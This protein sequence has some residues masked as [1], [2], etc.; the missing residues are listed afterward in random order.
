MAIVTDPDLLTRF[1]VIFGTNQ[2]K[3]SIFPVGAD[4]S[5]AEQ[6][7]GAIAATGIKATTT[8]NFNINALDG[9]DITI[10][11]AAEGGRTYTF[12]DTITVAADEIHIGVALTNTIDNLVNAIN[13]DGV[14]GTAGTDWST[15]TL[16][17]E[18]FTATNNDPK[19]TFLAKRVGTTS[20]NKT[21]IAAGTSVNDMDTTDTVV[22]VLSVWADTTV[23]GGTGDSTAGV[24]INALTCAA[25]TGAAA[26]DILCVYDGINAGH[27]VLQT[28]TT[29]TS[30]VIDG[31]FQNT[32]AESSL[33]FAVK[34]DER[35]SGAVQETRDGATIQAIYS[36]AKDEYKTDSRTGVLADDLIRHEFP[37][38]PITSEQFEV[39]GGVAHAEWDWFEGDY[40]PHDPVDTPS[41]AAGDEYTVKKVRTGG[42]AQVSAGTARTE[43]QYA[44]IIT[45]GSLDSDAQVYY[46]Q[47]SVT[48]TPVDFSFLSVVNEPI[49]VNSTGFTDFRT[50]LKLFVRKKARTYAGSTIGD[51]GV[52]TLSTIVNRFPLT[53]TT[54]PAIVE[55]DAKLLGIAPWRAITQLLTRS[56]GVTA[57]VDGVT[58]TMTTAVGIHAAGAVDGD[59]VEIISG[60]V[61]GDLG[62]YTVISTSD[63]VLTL[64]TTENGAFTGDTVITFDVD[65]TIVPGDG[66]NSATGTQ[67]DWTDGVTTDA[68]GTATLTSAGAG[69]FA[70]GGITDS[71][72]V[73]ITDPGAGTADEGYYDITNV[74]TTTITISTADRD[75]TT[76]TAVDFRI[77][78]PGMYL[79]FRNETVTNA[80]PAS[81]AFATNTITRAD[82]T[83]D[84]TIAP[85]TIITVTGSENSGENDGTFTVL[86]RTSGTI[87]TLLD[88]GSLTAITTNGTDTTAVCAVSDGWTRTISGDVVAFNWKM[89]ANQATLAEAFQFVQHQLRQPSNINFGPDNGVTNI[90]RGDIN[91]LLMSFSTPTGTTLNLVIDNIFSDDINNMT[92]QDVTGRNRNQPFTSSG[93]LVFN[94]NF[95]NDAD[96]TYTL[97]FTN[98]D[99][100]GDNDNSNFGTAAAIIVQEPDATPI[101]GDVVG[102]GNHT[103]VTVNPDSAGNIN[104]PFTYNYSGNVQRGASTGATVA[105][106]TLVAIGLQTAQYAITQTNITQATGL[107]IPATASLERN[108]LV[109]TV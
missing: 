78:Q 26:F 63:T 69:D 8:F 70:A 39:G 97:F 43:R 75:L 104:I 88:P 94:A 50:F 48:T 101:T 76:D 109:G 80:A 91:D 72:Y 5:G 68:T 66:D 108:Y 92:N 38:E 105:P 3:I 99:T 65:S 23:G 57:D 53:H 41:S 34:D 71:H 29:T 4:S 103:G 21:A 60:A 27:Y 24:D 98:N 83:W 59:T 45:L 52:T 16:E 9:E 22:D 107:S 49:L 1:E 42:W 67:T 58:G 56:D 93:S 64:D 100:P 37:Y 14:N 28:G 95:A 90:K 81:Y 84:T 61:A 30:M 36:F 31:S 86:A 11:L 13:Q 77:V 18:D 35:V 106:V 87:L 19:A 79:E 74:A 33:H 89:N 51:I 62:F 6:A 82:G 7:D 40:A 102:S 54:D 25:Y 55:E 46:Q 44:G 85:G 10:G 12:V 2:Q 96:S 73:L 17:N 15:V 20:T 32:T 47:T